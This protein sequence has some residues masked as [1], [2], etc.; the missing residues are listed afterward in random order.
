MSFESKNDDEWDSYDDN[1]DGWGDDDELDITNNM[2]NMKISGDLD[3][4]TGGYEVCVENQKYS[5]LITIEMGMFAEILKIY[6]NISIDVIKIHIIY[7]YR[8]IPDRLRVFIDNKP[9]ETDALILC[10]LTKIMNEMKLDLSSKFIPKICK[11]FVRYFQHDIYHKCYICDNVGV[12]DKNIFNNKLILNLCGSLLC[13]CNSF[14]SQNFIVEEELMTNPDRLEFMLYLFIYSCHVNRIPCI[15]PENT[16]LSEVIKIL[17]TLP[18]MEELRKVEDLKKIL[19]GELY[20]ILSW[21]IFTYM[22]KVE[23]IKTNKKQVIEFTS[24]T[25]YRKHPI[26]I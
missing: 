12:V 2:M 4:D 7:N 26:L 13:I 23:Y 25:S 15:L 18:S 6:T 11:R 21:L 24:V 22:N 20:S 3:L 10:K 5:K 19:T 8:L 1:D 14:I 9:T 16:E 17:E